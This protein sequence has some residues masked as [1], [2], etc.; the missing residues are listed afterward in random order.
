MAEVVARSNANLPARSTSR[1]R[2]REFQAELAERLRRASVTPSAHSRLAVRI[3]RDRGESN[4]L[5]DLPEAGEI[6]SVPD[7]TPVPLTRP[8]YLGLANVRGSLVSVVDIARFAGLGSTQLDKD[9]RVLAFSGELHFNA[10]I[11]VTRMLGL[12]NTDQLTPM[13][14]HDDADRPAWIGDAFR[15]Q[16]GAVWEELRLAALAA[17]ERFLQ[18]GIW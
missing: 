4:F 9:S 11:L 2:L 1:T 15:D 16:D 7:I 14:R 18:I 3:M 6:L 8:W 12:R 13:E 17:D 5:V 10:S